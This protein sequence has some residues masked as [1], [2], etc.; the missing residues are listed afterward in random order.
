MIP[1]LYEHVL[2]EVIRAGV[3]EFC[4]CPG[5]RNSPLVCALNN[6]K[7]IKTHYWYEERSAAFFA[8]GRARSSK[9]PVAVVTTS[10][11]AVGELLPAAMEAFYTGV[12]LLFLT[13]DRP[14]R[15][16]GTGAP[17]AAEQV[18]IFG[19]YTPFAQDLE[20]EERCLID[21]WD[22]SSPA[23]LNVCL[24]EPKSYRIET[25]LQIQ[26]PTKRHK[27]T[28]SPDSTPLNNFFAESPYPLILV[29]TLSSEEQAP[30]REFL[31]KVNAPIYCE[32]GSGLR[33]DPALE[34][35]QIRVES[36]I[37]TLSQANDYPIDGILR[38]GGIPVTR[39]WRDLEDKKNQLA[40]CSISELPFSG[41]SWGTHI[42]C[43]LKHFL[44]TYIPTRSQ[45]IENFYEWVNADRLL[46][47]E[48]EKLFLEYPAS[49]PALFRALSVRIP[50]NSMVY[51]GNSLPVREWDLGAPLEPRGIHIETSRGLNGIDG[52]LS[53]FL[54]LCEKGRENWAILGDL[55]TLYDF[56][57]LWIAHT[58]PEISFRVVVMNNGGGKIFSRIFKDPSFQNN[59]SFDFEPFANC[60]KIPYYCLNGSEIL[61]EVDSQAFIEV[62]PDPVET[63]AF[64]KAHDELLQ[65]VMMVSSKK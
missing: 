61:E 26:M 28:L 65:S 53:T 52:Q 7:Q 63:D 11:T 14:R 38:L 8:L 6:T 47:Q 51:L 37:W 35:L 36:S 25:P 5:A 9:S 49:E 1:P 64:W 13:A 18:N 23:H 32:S 31:L 57:G 15:F 24:E 42:Q 2:E 21:R 34:H 40:E 22:Q 10:G 62:C 30:V 50:K 39:I 17:Q 19:I 3:K 54:G 20:D 4:V 29:S 48:I 55:T 33:E 59:H 46:H 56:A 41:L 44:S 16:R 27:P 45:G 43:D 58:I 60:W 12:P